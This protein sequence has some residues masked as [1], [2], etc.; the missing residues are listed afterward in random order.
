M[1]KILYAFLL[2]ASAL[3]FIGHARAQVI[4]IANSNVKSDSISKG[5]LRDVFTGASTNLKGGSHVVPVLLRQGATHNQFVSDYLNKTA[6]SLLVG[7]RG[8]VMSGQATMPK[9]FD[10]ETEAVDY[11]ARTSGAIGYV[12]KATPHD[13]VKVL[14]VQ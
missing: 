2:A 4:V 10:S 8:L 6:I 9:T 11:V 1:K 13:S 12:S 3:T 7:W 5:E 14:T